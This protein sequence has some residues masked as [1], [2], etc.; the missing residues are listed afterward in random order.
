MIKP[1][2]TVQ[3]TREEL[4]VVIERYHV[5]LASALYEEHDEIEERLQ[6]LLRLRDLMSEGLS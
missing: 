2:F 4:Q 6:Q 1:L 5:E 3:L